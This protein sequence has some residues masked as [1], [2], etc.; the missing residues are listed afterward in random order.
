M[1]HFLRSL[2][3][4]GDPA[5]DVLELPPHVRQGATLQGGVFV[6]LHDLQLLLDELE[7]V[8]QSR[9]Q[10]QVEGAASQRVSHQRLV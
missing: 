5:R 1:Q 3:G 10:H 2:L 4:R 8:M 6:R 9:F 7:A